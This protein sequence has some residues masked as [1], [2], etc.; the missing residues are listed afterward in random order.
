MKRKTREK[1]KKAHPLLSYIPTTI[2][3][4]DEWKKRWDKQQ[5]TEE[6]LGLLHTLMISDHCWSRQKGVPFL[7][8]IADGYCDSEYRFRLAAEREDSWD[9]NKR[10][11]AGQRL[12]IAKKAMSVL[13]AKFFKR[14]TDRYGKV[15]YLWWWALEDEGICS[16]LFDFFLSGDSDCVKNCN[17]RPSERDSDQPVVLQFLKDFSKQ[18][19]EFENFCEQSFGSQDDTIQRRL[20]SYRPKFIEILTWLGTLQWLLSQQR[21]EVVFDSASL[22]KLKEIAL[23]KEYQLPSLTNHWE[24]EHRSPRNIREA[25]YAKSAAA[26]V[27]VIYGIRHQERLRSEKFRRILKTKAEEQSRLAQ[28]KQLEKQSALLRAEAERLLKS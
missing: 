21:V 18:G 3:S 2:G 7:L 12:M 1:T 5:S 20:I 26:E 16:S 13:C 9:E 28:A 25:V 10:E 6:R 23:D 19:W 22:G 11:A 15:S 27:L 4:F 17:R 8:E 24:T 14:Q